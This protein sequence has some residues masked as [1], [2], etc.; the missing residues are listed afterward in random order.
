MRPQLCWLE[1]D[2]TVGFLN[3]HLQKSNL[4]PGTFSFSVGSNIVHCNVDFLDLASNQWTSGPT[5]TTCRYQH[6]CSLITN[7]SS[8]Q[9]EIVVVGGHNHLV[10]D[11]VGE[12]NST[13]II[14]IDTKTVRS[15]KWFMIYKTWQY[16]ILCNVHYRTKLTAIHTTTFNDKL[17]RDISDNWWFI[18]CWLWRHNSGQEMAPQ[19]IDFCC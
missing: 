7:P 15:G 9:R 18:L 13:E 11:C 2:L 14:N 6:S 3:N 19:V 1:G 17:W 10:T 4:I 8:G 12:L 16:H 5:L